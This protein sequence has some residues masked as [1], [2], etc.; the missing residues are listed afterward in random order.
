[1]SSGSTAGAAVPSGDWYLQFDH[2]A[3]AQAELPSSLAP[4]RVA[5]IDSGIDGGHP[6]LTGSIVAARSFVGGSPLADDVGH[7]TYVAGQI[8]AVGAA[9]TTATRDSPLQLVVAKVVGADGT[10]EPAAEVAAI[11]WAVGEGARV[12]NLS[13]G[14]LRDPGHPDRDGYSPVE[15]AAVRYAIAHSAVVV[16]AVGNGGSAPNEPWPF[17][18]WPAALPHV[19]GVSAIAPDGSVPAFSNRDPVMNE[20]AAPGTDTVSTFPRSLTT[21]NSGCG[22]QGDSDCGPT[23]YQ[24]AEGTSF[25]AP[26]VAAAVALLLAADPQLT[27]DQ[28][29]WLLERSADD[30]TP[31]SG[32]TSCATGRDPLTGWGTLNITKAAA[33]LGGPLPTANPLEP[34]N[35]AGGQAAPLTARTTTISGDLDYW[36]N[37]LDV[38]RIHLTAGEHLHVHVSA[39]VPGTTLTLWKPGTT[40]VQ[41]AATILRRQRL[42]QTLELDSVS[43]VLYLGGLRRE[44]RS[45][46]E[47]VGV[48]PG[49]RSW[50]R[51]GASAAREPL[52]LP[53]RARVIQPVVRPAAQD[54]AAPEAQQQLAHGPQGSRQDS[55]SP[56]KRS[57]RRGVGPV[58]PPHGTPSRPHWRS[59]GWTI[60]SLDCESS[61]N[62]P[63][64]ASTRAANVGPGTLT[65]IRLQQPQGRNPPMETSHAQD[66]MRPRLTI[67]GSLGCV[68]ANRIGR[69]E[70][71]GSDRSHCP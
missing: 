16:A 27:P 2:V 1:M 71:P 17:A 14:A 53:T 33:A 32:C 40:H 31:A 36:E 7:G 48:E 8:V 46:G 26:Q 63:L 62:R 51:R 19:I 10:I 66:F 58:T 23:D 43:T 55:G 64:I 20:L 57:H 69:A 24:P 65:P 49:M 34:T 41:A 9:T 39:G 4:V 13:F 52:Q 28:V 67:S 68:G 42:A 50:R 29:S 5:V 60:E 59:N 3:E 22:D 44:N 37:P 21:L 45:L 11:R 6:A 18:D 61:L 30:A 47:E 15:A 56:S 38:Y 35:D 12:I 54:P 70:A 25:A